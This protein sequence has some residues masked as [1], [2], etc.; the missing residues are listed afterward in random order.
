MIRMVDSDVW[1][2]E[3]CYQFYKHS[4][5]FENRI[6]YNRRPI[7]KD[8]TERNGW[9]NYLGMLGGRKLEFCKFPRWVFEAVKCRRKLD[10]YRAEQI[11]GVYFE[12]FIDDYHRKKGVLDSFVLLKLALNCTAARDVITQKVCSSSQNAVPQEPEILDDE[13]RGVR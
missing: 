9:E 13:R 6:E 12:S 8:D 7:G 4:Y 2:D 3:W 10:S 11:C 1:I 5:K